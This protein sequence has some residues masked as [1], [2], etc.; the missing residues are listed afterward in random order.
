MGATKRNTPPTNDLPR[1]FLALV[2]VFADPSMLINF[3]ETSA[4]VTSVL[5]PW[6]LA[7]TAPLGTAITF[8]LKIIGGLM[9]LFNFH[10]KTAAWMLIAFS[11]TATVIYNL[12]WFGPQGEIHIAIFLKNL[13]I[14]GG[15]LF[16]TRSYPSYN[17]NKL[18]PKK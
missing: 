8:G 17:E 6:G 12:N 18:P 13:A 14:V 7:A 11:V 5:A 9:L 3:G 15:L 4:Y 1:I 10:T 16:F 2:F